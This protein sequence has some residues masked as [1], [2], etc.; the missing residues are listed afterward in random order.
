MSNLKV[1]TTGEVEKHNSK[2]DMWVIINDSVYDVS[3]FDKHPG[4]QDIFLDHAGQDATERFEEEGHSASAKK[5]MKDFLIGSVEG[6]VE[7]VDS[8][9]EEVIDTSSGTKM[10]LNK[11]KVSLYFSSWS[12]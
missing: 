8:D 3:N 10:R 9:I 12:Y 6:A 2:G 5:Q 11:I 7:K 4:G 1:Y